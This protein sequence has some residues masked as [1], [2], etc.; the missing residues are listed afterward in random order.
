MK[1]IIVVLRILGGTAIAF[2]ILLGLIGIAI[3]GYAA[4]KEAALRKAHAQEAPE[5]ALV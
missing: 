1:V 3:K 2:A 5:E 4:D